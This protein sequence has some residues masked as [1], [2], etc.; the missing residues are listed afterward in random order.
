MIKIIPQGRLGNNLLQNIGISILSKKLDLKVDQYINEEQFKKI[1]L[2]LNQGN[3][4]F[5][6]F[7]TYYDND[8]EKL[9]SSSE[10]ETGIIYDG[11]FQNKD[12]V[13]NYRSDILNH[14]NLKYNNI[15]NKDMFIHVRLGDVPNLTPG[16]NY[17]IESIKS[18]DFNNGYI[19]SDSLEHNIPKYLIKK[20]GLI[21]YINNPIDTINFAKN[22]NNIILSKGT[23]SWWI[24]LLSKAENIIFPKE[25]TDWPNPPHWHGN[26]FVFD[27]WKTISV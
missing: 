9:M 7:K 20:F 15:D 12:F 21:P 6:K 1:G 2:G 14:F 27:D 11:L 3:I 4:I 16:L 26:I 10:I 5:N 25:K 18:I 17:Y 13:I 23:F 8:L 22:F 19:S 24:G